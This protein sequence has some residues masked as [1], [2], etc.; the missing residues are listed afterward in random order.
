MVFNFKLMVFNKASRMRHLD[1]MAIHT[2]TLPMALIA[3]LD[4][5]LRGFWVQV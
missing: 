3:S 2:E 4:I 1:T 5:N